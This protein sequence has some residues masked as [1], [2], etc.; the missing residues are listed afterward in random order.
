MTDL[1]WAAIA[2]LSVGAYSVSADRGFSRLR[3]QHQHRPNPMY[4]A[5]ALESRGEEPSSLGDR[6]TPLR[7][8]LPYQRCFELWRLTD[9]PRPD[10]DSSRDGLL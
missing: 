4:V 7:L 1:R 6:A 5:C 2:S 9:D 10:S 8:D 3:G